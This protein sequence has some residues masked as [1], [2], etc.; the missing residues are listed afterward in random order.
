MFDY[1]R[2]GLNNSTTECKQQFVLP[3]QIFQAKL[4]VYLR[5]IQ[6]KHQIY[7]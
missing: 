1:L 7:P 6:V 2:Y 4:W 3:F 5:Q